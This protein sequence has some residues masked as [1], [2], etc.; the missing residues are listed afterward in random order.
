MKRLRKRRPPFRRILGLVLV[1][2]GLI[3]LFCVVDNKLRPI[4]QQVAT[5]RATAVSTRIINETVTDILSNMDIQYHELVTLDR[6]EEGQVT[7]VR[8]DMV[9]LNRF[10]AQI[11]SQTQKAI[12]GHDVQKIGIPIGT[13]IGGDLFTGRGPDFPVK[14][15]ISS[16]LESNIGNSF[17]EAGI[18][19]TMHQITLNIQ[20][21]V[22]VLIPWYRTSTKVTTNFVLA[23]TIIVGTVPEAFT[24][25]IG[26]NDPE[27]VIANY[28]A[29]VE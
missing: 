11:T 29:E 16:A 8:T 18:N 9:A 17:Q 20:T 5:S 12:D 4:M 2:T 25:V 15:N 26:S 7:S 6:N 13:I 19:Q 28:G 24:N 21:E 23:E 27:D 3:S 22:F 10:K 14:L 1:I